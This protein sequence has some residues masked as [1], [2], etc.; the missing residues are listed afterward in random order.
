LGFTEIQAAEAYFACEK[1]EMLAANL[2]LENVEGIPPDAE[3]H[4]HIHNE[5]TPKSKESNI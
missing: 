4:P 3:S 1:D 2:L 5:E